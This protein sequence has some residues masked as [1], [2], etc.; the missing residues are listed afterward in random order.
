MEESKFI[1]VRTPISEKLTL[2][3]LALLVFLF[4]EANPLIA[5][6]AVLSEIAFDANGNW[7][8]EFQNDSDIPFMMMDSIII[9]SSSGISKL[10]NINYTTSNIIV[11]RNDSLTTP[12]NINPNGDSIQVICFLYSHPF[13]DLPLIFG[14]FRESKIR[15]PRTGES[16]AG[17]PPLFSFSNLYSID[18]SPTI[19]IENDTTGMCCTIKGNIYDM[20]NELLHVSGGKFEFYNC[21]E[22]FYSKADGTYTTRVYSFKN[23]ITN[24]FYYTSDNKGKWL[25]IEPIMV[26]GEPDSII[27]MDIHLKTPFFSDI[28]LVEYGSAS[29]LKIY[30]NPIKESSFNY[31]VSIP[32]LSSESYIELINTAGQ[33]VAQFKLFENAGIINLPANIPVGNYTV[34]LFV[35]NRNYATE[36]LIISK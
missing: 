26:E 22:S 11:V 34:R 27:E 24:L 28:K 36:K 8:I 29:V 30:P 14:D 16:I 31:D 4:A 10:K 3:I 12:L 33:Q 35:K 15:S 2:T 20:N 23:T 25:D 17:V 6:G 21:P 13:Y 18:N 1:G 9:E 19:G 32:V 7:V 5:P